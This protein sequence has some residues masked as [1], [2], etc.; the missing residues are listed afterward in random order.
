[1]RQKAIA[2]ALHPLARKL[3]DLVDVLDPEML[4]LS[5]DDWLLTDEN[6]QIMKETI[7]KSLIRV[8]GREL[9]ITTSPL[10]MDGVLFGAALLSLHRGLKCSLNP[11]IQK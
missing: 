5:S 2:A 6:L 4:I 9:E 11:A 8:P 7:V 10:G 3:A 1:M